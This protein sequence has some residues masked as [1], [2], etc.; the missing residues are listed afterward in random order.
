MLRHFPLLRMRALIQAD[1]EQPGVQHRKKCVFTLQAVLA[2]EV[3][4][5]GF[6][7][8]AGLIHL[9]LKCKGPRDLCLVSDS[10]KGVGLPRR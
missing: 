9:A 5:D 3:I 7:L 1:G 4:V 8:H 6:H 2:T 10:M